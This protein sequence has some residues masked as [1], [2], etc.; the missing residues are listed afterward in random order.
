MWGTQTDHRGGGHKRPLAPQIRWRPAQDHHPWRL[1]SFTLLNQFM[2]EPR[3]TLF[4]YRMWVSSLS[5]VQSI[6]N[7]YYR[8]WSFPSLLWAGWLRFPRRL[9]L[10]IYKTLE[11]FSGCCSL[12]LSL[13]R[14][15]G[16]SLRRRSQHRLTHE[17]RAAS[18]TKQV[19][20]VVIAKSDVIAW[21]P[22]GARNTVTRQRAWRDAR[23][24]PPIHP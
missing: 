7:S 18:P 14:K 20:K 23:P 5:C 16:G 3:A 6:S 12:R 1:P 24:Q 21:A 2:A 17:H 8:R 9:R 15:L 10:A 4:A 19:Q 13:P 22:A 11:R